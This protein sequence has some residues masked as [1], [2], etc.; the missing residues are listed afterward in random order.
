VRGNGDGNHHLSRL[1]H[2]QVA[3]TRSRSAKLAQGYTGW[4][5]NFDKVGNAIERTYLDA[6]DSPTRHHDGYAGWRQQ[7]D[8]NGNVIVFTYFDERGAPT[9]NVDGYAGWRSKFDAWGNEIERMYLDE[10]GEVVKQQSGHV[11]WSATFDSR[12]IEVERTDLDTPP[13]PAPPG[14][15]LFAGKA[16]DAGTHLER[17]NAAVPRSAAGASCDKDCRVRG[18]SETRD[19]PP[20]DPPK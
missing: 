4:K 7:F 8:N 13:A 14:T 9:R 3:R 18:K 15:E 10:R 16:E 17:D 20:T 5:T 1:H 11:G 12:G 6:T 19:G 2:P